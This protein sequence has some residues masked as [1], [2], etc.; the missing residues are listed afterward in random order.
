MKIGII[1]GGNMGLLHGKLINSNIELTLSALYDTFKEKGEASAKELG[2]KFVETLDELFDNCEM[3]FIT[4]P[5]TMHADLAISALK[6]KKHVFVEKPLATS[7]EDAKKVMEASEKSGKRVFVG[8]NRRFAPVYKKAKD[9]IFDDKFKPSNINIIQNDGDMINPPWLTDVKMT[10]GFMYDTTVHFLDMARY[11]MGEITEIRALGKAACYPII[12][13]FAVLITFENGNYGVISTC[14]HASWISP[15]ERVQVVGD[16]TSIIT[17]ELDSL[18]FSPGLNKVID[19]KDFSKLPHEEKWGYKFMHEHMFDALKNNK[20]AL[21]DIKDGY[22]GVK[23]MEA[24][25]ESASK[26][27]QLIKMD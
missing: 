5:N 4:V 2:T 14:G 15:F 27:G 17:E 12:D 3:V 7:I 16:H 20:E 26:N 10:G 13:D 21:N 24:C 1:G 11:L 18:R 9:L 23:L 6:A 25:Y 8:Y 22:I 19:A